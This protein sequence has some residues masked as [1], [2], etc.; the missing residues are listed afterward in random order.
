MVVV[1]G[2]RSEW[3]PQPVKATV[4]RISFFDQAVFRGITPVLANAFYTE[5]IPYSWKAGVLK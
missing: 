1:E 3:Q 4:D 2:V 5:Q